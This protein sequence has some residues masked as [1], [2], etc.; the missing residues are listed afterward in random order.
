MI[1]S[2]AGRVPLVRFLLTVTGVDVNKKTK[3]GQTA[4]HY[5]ASKSHREVKFCYS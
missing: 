5:A 1:A 2:S 3:N 4:L